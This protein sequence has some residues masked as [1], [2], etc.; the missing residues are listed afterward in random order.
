VSSSYFES[1]GI[2]LLVVTIVL[3]CAALGA[4]VAG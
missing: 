1:L 4:V 3:M 2:S